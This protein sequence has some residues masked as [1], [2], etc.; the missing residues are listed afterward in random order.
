MRPCLLDILADPV[1]PYYLNQGT[2]EYSSPT[3]TIYNIT[4]TVDSY[5]IP[6]PYETTITNTPLNHL[7]IDDA[8]RYLYQT[9]SEGL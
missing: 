5:N 7:T 9:M 6:F 3:G 4:R 1:K 2:L 8:T